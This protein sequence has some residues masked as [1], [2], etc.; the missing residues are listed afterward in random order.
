MCGD[1]KKRRR[2]ARQTVNCRKIPIAQVIRA[3]LRFS[4]SELLVK[5]VVNNSYG[6]S[7]IG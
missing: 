4:V 2:K 3:D 1:R 6:P 7:P 5:W